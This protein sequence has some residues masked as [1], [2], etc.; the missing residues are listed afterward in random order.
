MR[1]KIHA[2]LF[3]YTGQ[4]FFHGIIRIPALFWCFVSTDLSKKTYTNVNT[5]IRRNRQYYESLRI[6]VKKSKK[7]YFLGTGLKTFS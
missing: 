3:F 4:K 7:D 1:M 2:I 5:T 6:V